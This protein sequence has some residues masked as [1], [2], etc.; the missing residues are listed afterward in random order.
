MN[1]QSHIIKA[2]I[3][4]AFLLS[5]VFYTVAQISE[6]SWVKQ[7]GSKTVP[8]GTRTFCVN[9]YG[10]IPDGLSLC[11]KAIQSA[12]DKCAEKGGGI[13]C[14]KKGKYLT[15][16]LFVKNNVTLLIDSGVMIMG[17]Q[18]LM[19][20]PDI[21]T[22]VAGIEMVW[23]AA[24]I[25]VLDQDNV[26]IC[27][28]GI[29]DA[30]GAPFW[31]SYAIMRR[32]YTPKNL[33]WVVDYDCKRPR[34]ML[35]S[36]SSNVTL[37]G[38]TLQRAG[39]WTVQVLYSKD[40]SVDGLIIRNNIGGHGPSTDGVDI[41][42]S[43]RVLVEN[44]DI[45]CN[46]DN[47]CLKAGR[48]ADGLRVNRPCEYVVIRNCVAGAG[49]GLI[50]CG[51]ETS[52]SIR[53]IWVENLSAK[54]TQ[55]GFRVKSALTRGGVVENIFLNNI[56]MQDVAVP[57]EVTTNWN[58]S[59]SYSSLPEGYNYDSVPDHWKKLVDKVVPASAGIPV[60]RK[61]YI[62]NLKAVGARRALSVSGMKES[63]I[64]GFYFN[65]VRIEARSAGNIKFS[66]DW[67]FNNVEI[68]AP[69]TLIISDCSDMNLR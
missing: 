7:V 46:D 57:I 15:G 37:Q 2:T 58:P 18:N 50:T 1:Q 11:T 30:Q 63:V 67:K 12:I 51:S 61:I 41:D 36:R 26:K 65:N 10:A 29:V 60:F 8:S 66:R 24:L 68:V 34:T 19:D 64:N 45:D 52:G 55:V 5:C 16:S 27:G 21:D 28:K 56:F 14:F 17:S 35:V 13:V 9:D 3:L 38:L 22:R 23:P 4:L 39:F 54:G 31:E 59:Y 47:F 43:T 62:N 6:P 48:D 53:N 49:G 42:S 32:E 69:D 25:N 20:Y 40:I 33:R 44:C